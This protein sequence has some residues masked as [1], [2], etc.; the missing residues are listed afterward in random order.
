MRSTCAIRGWRRLSSALEANSDDLPGFEESHERLDEL[1]VR[2]HELNVEQSA[3]AASKQLITQRYQAALAEAHTVA[4]NLRENLRFKYGKTSEKLVE[5]GIRP[6]RF[7]R[8]RPEPE[9]QQPEPPQPEPQT[10]PVEIAAEPTDP[11]A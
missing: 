7:L 8:R 10:P 1:L 4:A 6:F 2:I 5:F 3:L 11:T 9:P